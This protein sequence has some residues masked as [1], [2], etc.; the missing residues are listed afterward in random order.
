ME[1]PRRA[2]LSDEEARWISA[3]DSTAGAYSSR[4]MVIAG[5][6]AYSVVA[7]ED[8]TEGV[9]TI[10]VVGSG[11]RT[12]QLADRWR[13]APLVCFTYHSRISIFLCVGENC[14]SFCWGG[15]NGK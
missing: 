14:I 5:G 7:Y 15:V 8:T 3:V 9:Q 10:E 11:N 4:D 6:T 13:F 1:A 12:H 2:S